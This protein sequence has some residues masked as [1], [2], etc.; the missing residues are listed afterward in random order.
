[1]R[2]SSTPRLLLAA[3]AVT[4]SIYA[5]QLTAQISRDHDIPLKNWAAPLYWQPTHEAKE[6]SREA[7]VQS[8]LRLSPDGL[9]TSQLVFVGIT[10]CRVVDTRT[11]AGFA[12]PFGPPSLQGGASRTFPIQSST[13]SIPSTALAY[14]FNV[15]V[16][17]V[18]TPGVNPPGYLGFLTVYPTGQPLPNAS[19][20]NN[21]LGTVVANA[22]VVPAGTSGS[23]DVY[24]LQTTDFI[25]DING[26]YVQAGSGSSPWATNG[27]SVYY[28]GGSIGIGTVSPS[29]KL[30]VNGA[31]KFS[32]GVV[33]G[34]GTTQTTA[35]VQGP[36]GPAG[37][38]G[39]P[40]ASGLGAVSVLDANN[41]TLGSALAIGPMV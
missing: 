41:N 14:S 30:E 29:Q 39:P 33:F 40:G 10:P 1:M 34:D 28:N 3:F 26:Y 19:T 24:A 31:A 21:Y 37:P 8:D 15:T 13:C 6:A 25:M 5:Q 35:T 11:G 4:A 23:V 27:S 22:C 16:V 7:T 38:Q 2:L 17:P 20:L 18:T 9:T 12:S 32:G 36:Q